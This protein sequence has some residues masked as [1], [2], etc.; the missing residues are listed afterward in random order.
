MNASSENTAPGGAPVYT[1]SALNRE[2]R[3]LL[4]G[5]FPL[6]WVEGEISNLARPASGHM[7]FSLKDAGAQ[8]RCAMFRGRSSRLSFKVDNGLK[9]LVRAKVSLYEA[10][11]EFQLLVEHMEEAGHGAL[12]RAFEE[13]KRRLAAEGLFEEAAKRPVP[14][15]PR[16]IGV[17]TSPTGAAIRDILS[18]LKRRFPAV[19]VR[20]Y[21]TAVQGAEAAP[22]IVQM[23]ELASQRADCDVLILARGG[24]SLEDL[25][26]F[27]EEAVARAI[28]ACQIP[29]ISGVGHE[30]DVTIADFAAD[31]RAATPTAA[32]EVATP[33]ALELAARFAHGATNLA[34]ALHR[35]LER[36]STRLKHLSARLDRLHPGRRLLERSQRLDELEQRLAYAWRALQRQRGDRLGQL[37]A[38]LRAQAPD[39]R[40]ARL[41]DARRGLQH[42][43]QAAVQTQLRAAATRLAGTVR[44]LEAIS[45][46]ATLER[47]YAILSSPPGE[48]VITD[49]GKLTAGELIGVQVAHGRLTARVE[50]VEKEEKP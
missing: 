38:E 34:R 10:R 46:L 27:N 31:R 44:A 29:V 33:D 23:L 13:L 28:R 6:I 7:Y 47:G 45:P 30:V 19:P 48:T 5:G 35:G 22:R 15:L 11:G 40:L 20:I 42:R 21:P 37:R 9:V 14:T 2:I 3:Y 25:W 12:Q 32:A 1:V 36:V 39:Q 4:E 16:R 17:I 8:V 18:V 41:Q 26:P 50:T 24:G 49:A 43:L